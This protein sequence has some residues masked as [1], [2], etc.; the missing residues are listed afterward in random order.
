MNRRALAVKKLEGFGFIQ[1]LGIRRRQIFLGHDTQDTF[2]VNCGRAK[3]AQT[4]L[5]PFRVLRKF[6]VHGKGMIPRVGR[7]ASLELV[8]WS[9]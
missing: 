1:E 3:N 2:A 6:D 7:V 8:P 5:I 4:V 9:R